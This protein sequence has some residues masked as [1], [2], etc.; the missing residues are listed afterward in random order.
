L[1]DFALLSDSTKLFLFSCSVLE[2]I[3]LDHF[4]R[5]FRP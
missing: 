5:F 2:V 1:L 3:A 4:D